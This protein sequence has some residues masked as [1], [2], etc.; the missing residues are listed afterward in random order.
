MIEEKKGNCV[1]RSYR[2]MVKVSLLCLRMSLKYDFNIGNEWEII[3]LIIGDNEIIFDTQITTK[4]GFALG[5]K[6]RPLLS[7]VGAATFETRNVKNKIHVN[8]LHQI[9]GQYGKRNLSFT[10]KRWDMMLFE[11]LIP[12]RYIPLEKH[13]KRMLVNT[14]QEVVS[15]LV[16]EFMLK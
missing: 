3:K 7:D 5:I 15:S 1:V 13:N 8:N 2:K 12:V 6:M 14:G 11:L 9:L 16:S 10:G 4:H